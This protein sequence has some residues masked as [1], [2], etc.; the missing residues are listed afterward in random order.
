LVVDSFN[1][2]DSVQ[3]D[4]LEDIFDINDG[5]KQRRIGGI[6]RLVS[7]DMTLATWPQEALDVL[8]QGRNRFFA[9]REGPENPAE[10]TQEQKEF[11]IVWGAARDFAESN[12]YSEFDP[13][14]FPSANSPCGIVPDGGCH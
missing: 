9:E 1:A 8:L 14:P 6:R 5:I 10:K 12:H 2:T 3:C 7:A 13:A 4:R 11:T